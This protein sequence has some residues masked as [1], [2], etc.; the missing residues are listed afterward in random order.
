MLTERPYRAALSQAEAACELQRG[1]GKQ[2][3]PDVVDAL[4]DLLGHAA[5]DV[6]DRSEGIRMPAAPPPR[7]P[8]R[9]GRR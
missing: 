4:L 7:A 5:P 3:D 2:F 1:A 6:P 8:G 9:R